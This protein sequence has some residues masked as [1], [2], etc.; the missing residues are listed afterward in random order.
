MK[1]E[2]GVKP[3]FAM[4]LLRGWQRRVCPSPTH[5]EERQSK[6]RKDAVS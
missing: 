6:R 1:A 4:R 3:R 5:I 2:G